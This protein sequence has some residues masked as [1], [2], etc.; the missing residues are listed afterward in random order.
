[1]ENSNK[2]YN[3]F[4]KYGEEKFISLSKKTNFNYIFLNLKDFNE[5]L[6]EDLKHEQKS[7]IINSLE[8]EF[9]NSTNKIKRKI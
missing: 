6:E 1:M 7:R 3:V 8:N 4:R 5:R 9:N 2:A